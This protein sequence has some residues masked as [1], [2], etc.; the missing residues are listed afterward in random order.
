MCTEFWW[1][2]LQ[3]KYQLVVL[4]VGLTVLRIK[5]DITW[6]GVDWT[7]LVH[8]MNSWWNLLNA[9]TELQFQ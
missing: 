4:G 9:V 8:D 6:Q 1:G 2:N 5:M 7:D 3:E